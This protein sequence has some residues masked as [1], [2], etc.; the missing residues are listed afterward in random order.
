[1][2]VSSTTTKVSYNGDNSTTVFAYTFKIFDDDDITVILRT[3][4]TGTESVQTKTTDYSVSGVGNT[5]G[6]NITFVTAPASGVTVVLLRETA[7]TQTTDYTPNDPFPA[8]SHED[9]LDKIT[10]TVQDQQEELNRALKLS[11]TNTMAST[12]FTVGATTRA[13]K[14]LAFDSSGELAV[15]QEIGTFQGNWT[16]STS[17]FERDLVRDTTTN[18]IFIVNSAH[19]SSGSQPLT[20]NANSAKYDLILEAELQGNLLGDTTPQLGGNL[21]LN[22]NDITGTGNIKIT[23]SVGIGTNSPSA[24]LHLASNAPYINFE[25][26][27]NNQDWQLQ[28]TAW[29]AL[30]NQTTNSELL[31]VTSGGN[32]GIGTNLP[33]SGTPLHV[34]ESSASLGANPA[35]SAFLVERAGNVGMTLGTANTGECSIFMGDTD[36]LT[37]GRVQYDNSNDSLQFWANSIERMRIDS[38]GRLL[39]NRTSAANSGLIELDYAP[40]TARDKGIVLNNSNGTTGGQACNFLFSGTTVGNISTTASS[41]SYNTSSDYRLKENVVADWDATT[42]LKQLNPVRFNFIADADTTVD[43]FL[44]HEVQDVVPEAVTG[45]KDAMQNEEYEVT[46]AVLDDDGNIVT[47]AVM[48]TRSVP[49]YQGID[50]SKLVPLLVKTIQELEARIASLEA[51]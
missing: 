23:G 12:E 15:T 16:A 50:Q 9:A 19:T 38:S 4:A 5:N 13:N 8:S 10:L 2:T 22:S 37:A 46:P 30:R 51:N 14:I 31:R 21:D 45:T 36:S 1:M 17:Y 29:F 47:D 48:G 41:T 6:G 24:L 39:V 49:E 40:I 7:Q 32:V 20:T 27:D 42:R 28:A 18:N 25:D 44:A 43:G 35:A 3:V 26:V 11:R 33:D 34:E